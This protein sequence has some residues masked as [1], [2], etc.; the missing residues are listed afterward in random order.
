MSRFIASR[1]LQAIPVIFLASVLVFLLIKL[2]PGDPAWVILGENARPE[3]YEYLRVKMGLDQPLYVQ[4]GRWL[5]QVLQG[6]LGASQ[7]NKFP[8]GRMLVL[9]GQATAELALGA[10]FVV[11]GLGFPIGI[12][13]AVKRGS[14]IDRV[15]TLLTSVFYAV[16]TFWLAILLV[17]FV[18][19]RWKLLPPSGR[20]APSEDFGQFLRLLILPAITL[21]VHSSAVLA[22]YVKM[23]LLEVMQQ[24]YIRTARS[25][26]LT[27]RMVLTRHALRNALIPVVTVLGLQLGSLLGG[28]VVTESIY[29]WPG[30]GSMAL[31]GI[32]TR[33]YPVVQGVVLF[34]VV[35]FVLMNLLVDLTYG[36]LDPRVR[37][38]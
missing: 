3:E 6:D 37:Y 7:I 23:S 36:F 28:A 25:K 29:R 26:G 12:L 2:I 5:F 16:P 10:M 11:V 24:D 17:L 18:S 34:V 22:R 38:E 14:L 8:V 30:L 27:E 33:D 31:R 19:L 13:A 1:V 4:Y 20:V 32:M 9:K 35:V 21:G 15:T